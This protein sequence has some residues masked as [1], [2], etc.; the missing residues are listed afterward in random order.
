[1]VAQLNWGQRFLILQQFCRYRNKNGTAV[2]RFCFEVIT[3]G[4]MIREM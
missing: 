4:I 3:Q 1:M 2:L